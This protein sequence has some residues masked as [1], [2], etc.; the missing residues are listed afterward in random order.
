M[1]FYIGDIIPAIL[2][3]QSLIFALVLFGDAGFKRRANFLLAAFFLVMAIQFFGLLA[4]NF[5]VKWEFFGSMACIYGFAYGPLLY[6]YS[7]SLIYKESEFEYKQLI[8]LLPFVFLAVMAI[9][10]ISV[11]EYAGAIMYLSLIGYIAVSIK[12][13]IK[14]RNILK[15]VQSKEGQIELRWLQN[16][17]VIFCLTLLLDIVDQFVLGLDITQGVSSIHLMLLFLI[18]WV[19]Y[20]GLKQP[21]IF[22]GISRNDVNIIQN[23]QVNAT[24]KKPNAEEHDELNR[25]DEFMRSSEIYIDPDL[26]INE[27][28]KAVSIPA[29]RL[30]FLIN[31]FL[32]KNFIGYINEFRIELAKERLKNPKDEGETISEIM[33][34]VGFSSKSSFNSF[35]KNHTG[36]T[37][38]QFRDSR[39]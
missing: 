15:Q 26:N 11:C 19:F 27:L 24:P 4:P 29:R 28:A 31:G 35:F 23:Q 10:K 13:L 38:S 6:F 20:K 14:Y 37:P 30:S 7:R 17:M 16:F 33:Y 5:G 21:Q 3:F 12:G 39:S 9:S 22:M 25:L 34:D 2:L 18:N 36:M 8:H 32:D 1:V